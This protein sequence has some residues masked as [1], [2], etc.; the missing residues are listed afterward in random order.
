L[1]FINWSARARWL[2]LGETGKLGSIFD[3]GDPCDP[4]LFLRPGH[5][6]GRDGLLE[7]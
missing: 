7:Q 2:R 1:I 5:R 6:V 4:I 3:D